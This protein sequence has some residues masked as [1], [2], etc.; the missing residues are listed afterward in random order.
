MVERFGASGIAHGQLDDAH[1]L[2]DGGEL[3]VVDFRG[4]TVAANDAQRRTDEAQAFVTTLTLSG[5]QHALAGARDALGDAGLAA[6][7]P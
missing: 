1:L 7:L 2:I 5:E 3:G 4:A 6:M